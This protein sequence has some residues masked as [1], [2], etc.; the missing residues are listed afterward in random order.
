MPLARRD[1]SM[2]LTN[3]SGQLRSVNL[4]IALGNV[5]AAHLKRWAIYAQTRVALRRLTGRF[6][7]DMISA[8]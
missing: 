3:V 2:G 1:Y 4:N 8:P 7:G 5:P 6:V